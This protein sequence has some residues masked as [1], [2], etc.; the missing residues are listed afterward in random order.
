[1]AEPVLYSVYVSFNPDGE[2]IDVWRNSNGTVS[3][4]PLDVEPGS[5]RIQ[6]RPIDGQEGLW[7]FIDL[8]G[9]PNPPFRAKSVD[10]QRIEIDDDNPGGTQPPYHYQI[11]IVANGTAYSPDPQ[12]RNKPS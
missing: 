12:I 7:R 4:N 3:A 11:E 8:R 2:A 5:A 10:P 6:W 9:L 1:M